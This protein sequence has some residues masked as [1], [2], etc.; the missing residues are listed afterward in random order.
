M[1]TYLSVFV[2][3][4]CRLISVYQQGYKVGLEMGLNEPRYTPD[5]NRPPGGGQIKRQGVDIIRTPTISFQPSVLERRNRIVVAVYNY[6]SREAQD[7]SF[8]KGDRMQVLDDR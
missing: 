8:R 4:S 6:E 7:V 5:P 2:D 3:E 1:L